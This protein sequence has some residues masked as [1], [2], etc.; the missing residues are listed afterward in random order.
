MHAVVLAAI[1]LMPPHMQKVTSWIPKDNTFN[2]DTWIFSKQF[3][4]LTKLWLKVKI[5]LNQFT[6]SRVNNLLLEIF[7]KAFYGKS[8]VKIKLLYL[9]IHLW[10]Q[11]ITNIIQKQTFTY[12]W[13]IFATNFL[14]IMKHSS[15]YHKEYFLY[16]NENSFILYKHYHSF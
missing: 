10:Q 16:L 3:H 7:T 4:L 1:S 15:S 12:F 9:L 6:S 13:R 14:I 5:L 2:K 11:F 8:H